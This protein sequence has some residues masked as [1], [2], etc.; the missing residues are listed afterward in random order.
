VPAPAVVERFDVLEDGDAC[1]GLGRPGAAV[2]EVLLDRRVKLSSTALSKQ[3]PF[4][5]IETSIPTARQ[6]R[7]KT[8]DVY[9]ADSSGRRNAR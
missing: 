8:S 7:V 4:A 2:D 9:W 3:L 5:P 1:L 6:R